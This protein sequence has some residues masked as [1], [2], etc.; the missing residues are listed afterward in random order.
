M[1]APYGLLS[2]GFNPATADEV[3]EAI[4]QGLRDRFGASLPVDDSTFEGALASLVGMQ[5]GAVWEASEALAGAMDPDAAS[6]ALLDAL[7]AITGTTRD[8]ETNSTAVLTLTG[9]TGTIVTGGSRVALDS[10]DEVEFATDEDATLSALTAWV[11]TT[12][13]VVGDRRTNSSRAYVCIT[14]G[15]SAGS[16]GPTTTAADI[17][18][19]T[20]HWRYVGEGTAAVD[21]DATADE[22]GPVVATS[23]DLS[24]IVTPISGWSSAINLLDA[25]L[26]RDDETDASLRVKREQELSGGGASTPDAI[27]AAVLDVDGVT[28]CT[29]FYNDTD[30]T[31]ADGIPPHAVEVLVVG[32]EDQDIWNAL[33]ASVAAGIGMHGDEVGTWTDSEGVSHAAAFSRPEERTIYVD[34]VLTKVAATY[35]GDDAVKQAIVTLGDA[36]GIGYDVSAYRI[37]VFVATVAG[38]FEVTDVDIGVTA[39]PTTGITVTVTNRQIAVFDTSRITVASSDTIP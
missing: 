37:G 31:D 34:V 16:G 15:T 12:A 3:I 14:A 36:L 22:T 27:R 24:V 5:I 11:N 21:V 32:G 18:D 7:C 39:A 20:V 10:D 4:K 6:A 19:G 30:T 28:I 17:T 23:G 2:T 9:T 29:V 35:G 38:V 33:G 13:Y 26:G 1:P 25:D 8:D